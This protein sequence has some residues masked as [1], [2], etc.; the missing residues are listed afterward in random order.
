MPLDL[1]SAAERESLRADG[2]LDV[3]RAIPPEYRA[4]V[5][6]QCI[7]RV[8][9]RRQAVWTQGENAEYVAFLVSGAAMSLYQTPNGRIGT[10]GFWCAGDILGAGDIGLR[11]T[12][13]MTVRCL[14]TSV[15][16][17]LSYSR[18][19]HLLRR[20]PELADTVIRALSLR[21]R[22]VSQ[23]AV[24][25]ETQTGVERICAALLAL[26]DRFGRS[27]AQGTLIDLRLTNEDLA[28]ISGLS[29]QFVNAT[30]SQLRKDGRLRMRKRSMI[31]DREA[32]AD[33]IGVNGMLG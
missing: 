14:D 13:L 30:L 8:V 26:A 18:F 4:A 28:A 10:T 15:I 19:Q 3:F 7:R 31:V 9:P 11:T 17:T 23:L 21:L 24:M 1:D 25:L 22:W 12:R 2:H 20:F 16:Y 5:L 29:R 33:A 6:E 32:L 27:E